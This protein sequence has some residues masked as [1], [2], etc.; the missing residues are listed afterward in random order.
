MD[1]SPWGCKE[2]DMTEVTKH[3]Q[4][5]TNVRGKDQEGGKES[6]RFDVFSLAG[7]TVKF[8]SCP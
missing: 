4:T 6:G 7:V 5:Q 2:L 8:P 1:Y 3:T